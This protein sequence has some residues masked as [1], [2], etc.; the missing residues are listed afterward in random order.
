[1][2][3]LLSLVLLCPSQGTDFFL[4]LVL[5]WLQDW[6]KLR[7]C[8]QRSWHCWAPESSISGFLSS[9]HFLQA[10][11]LIQVILLLCACVSASVEWGFVTLWFIIRNMCLI[12]A[13]F[14]AHSSLNP[15]N[16]PSA[17]SDGGV[18]CYVNKW[19]YLEAPKYGG[20]LPGEPTMWLVCWNFQCPLSPTLGRGRELKVDPIT[21]C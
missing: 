13:L 3:P 1:M 4:R 16:F 5:S 14:L 6:T 10:V 17:K 20:W 8:Q 19:L 7:L 9:S 2:T 15:W 11:W 18:F 12:F 21:N